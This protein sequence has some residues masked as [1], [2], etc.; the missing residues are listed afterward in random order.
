MTKPQA[1]VSILLALLISGTVAGACSTGSDSPT[2]TSVPTA[3]I[4]VEDL[5]QAFDKW[6]EPYA[7]AGVVLAAQTGDSEPWMESRGFIDPDRTKSMKTD[8]RFQIGAITV[9]FVATLTMQLVEEGVLDLEQTLDAYVPEI[10]NSGTITIEQLLRHESGI[11][12]LFDDEFVQGIIDDPTRTWTRDEILDIASAQDP[13]FAPGARFRYSTLNY[14]LLGHII[15]LATESTF[16][17]ELHERILDPLNLNDTF[18]AGDEEIID[19]MTVAY[20]DFNADGSNE[21]VDEA[22]QTAWNTAFWTS[23]AMV[24]TASDLLRF[25]DALFTG[26][27]LEAESL[28]EMMSVSRLTTPYGIGLWVYS[29]QTFGATA[30]GNPSATTYDAWL[31]HVPENNLTIVAWTNT[32]LVADIPPARDSPQAQPLRDLVRN[33]VAAAT[34]TDR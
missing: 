20:I 13:L 11:A 17:A 25:S 18:V 19:G 10:E 23:G 21:A 4:S 16:V 5:R 2:E 29:Q 3:S 32:T 12:T 7:P 14:Y 26:E 31:V 33:V 22:S 1:L 9:M 6:H 15:E 8:D 24:S 28:E 30:W 27:L 34:E